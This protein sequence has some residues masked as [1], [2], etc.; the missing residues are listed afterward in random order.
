MSFA[1]G[2]ITI[3]SAGGTTPIPVY[4]GFS[5][6]FVDL[7]VAFTDG[8]FIS[9]SAG[10]FDGTLNECILGGMTISGGTVDSSIE[11]VGWLVRNPSSLL[12]Q[13]TGSVTVT[14]TGFI[15]TPTEADFDAQLQWIAYADEFAGGTETISSTAEIDI[16]GLSFRPRHIKIN[17]IAVNAADDFIAWSSGFYDGVNNESTS[18]TIT[19][20]GSTEREL[21]DDLAWRPFD[22]NDDNSGIVTDLIDGGFTLEPD[23]VDFTALLV[24]NAFS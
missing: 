23:T 14:S 24:W 19:S 20:T 13:N 11:S 9:N 6:S 18:V 15:L 12:S 16:T 17:A 22:F 21:N 5:P 7:Q 1:A 10:F 8:A 3:T 2:V 4:L